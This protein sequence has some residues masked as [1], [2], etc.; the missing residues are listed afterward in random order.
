MAS[1]FPVGLYEAPRERVE[2]EI[3]E[4]PFYKRLRQG[5]DHLRELDAKLAQALEIAEGLHE[6]T[7]RVIEDAKKHVVEELQGATEIWDN[8]MG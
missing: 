3:N 2:Q 7:R 6:E 1:K 5:I 8:R 4:M